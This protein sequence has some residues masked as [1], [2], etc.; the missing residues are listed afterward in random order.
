MIVVYFLLM[1]LLLVLLQTTVLM[2]KTVWQFSPDLYFILVAYLAYRMDVLR[3][4]IILFPLS[5]LLDVFCGT[6]LG[7]YALLCFGCFFGIKSV[8]GKIPLRADLYQI[9]LIGIVYLLVN[10]LV[11]LLLELLQPGH[12][13]P[14]FSWQIIIRALLVV[15][16]AYP[17][18]YLFDLMIK[19]SNHS[20][21]AWNK[22]R[23][24]TDNRRRRHA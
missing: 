9:P 7:S 22:L 16:L 2:P 4:L 1:G 18:F 19:F 10:W 12:Q 15:L 24:R 13:V 8:S 20:P 23:L 17:L 11:Y 21:L 14:W 3:S 5:C 6:I